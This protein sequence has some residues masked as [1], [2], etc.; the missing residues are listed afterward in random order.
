MCPGDARL[1]AKD[2]RSNRSLQLEFAGGLLIAPGTGD[3]GD[4]PVANILTGQRI[5][6]LPDQVAGGGVTGPGRCR[7]HDANIAATD[8][9]LVLVLLAGGTGSGA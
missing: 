1:P 3:K 5:E 8:D 2:T 6:A 9:G 7:F 4:G